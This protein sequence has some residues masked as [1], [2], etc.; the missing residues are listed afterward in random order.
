VRGRG[1]DITGWVV[2]KISK[3]WGAEKSPKRVGGVKKSKKDGESLENG[4][5]GKIGKRLGVSRKDW[6]Q[7]GGGISRAC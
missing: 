1:I 4:L 3:R 6:G 7:K 2:L 5:G